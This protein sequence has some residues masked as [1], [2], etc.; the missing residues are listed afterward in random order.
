MNNNQ[1]PTDDTNK[2]VV[3]LL[4]DDEVGENSASGN[5]PDPDTANQVDTNYKQAFGNNPKG[6][7]LAEEVDEDE[8]N[9]TEE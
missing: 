2:V 4:T 5:T 8:K 1:N 7:T 6:E 9:R 3:P